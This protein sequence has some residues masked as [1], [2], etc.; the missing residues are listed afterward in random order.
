MGVSGAA[1]IVFSDLDYTVIFDSELDPQTEALIEAVR[2]R[3]R[4]VIVTARSLEECEP[5]PPIPSDA[6]VAENGAAVYLRQAGRDVLDLEWDRRMAPY[7]AALDAMRQELAAHGW[8]IHH[9]LRAFS[10]GVERSGKSARDVEWARGRLP[11]GLQLQLSRNTA[12]AYLEVF[13]EVAGKD[14][15]VYRVCQDH[16]V[17]PE[18]SFGLGDNTNDLDMLRVVGYPLAPGNCHPEVR[19]LV[20][21]RGG[22]VAKEHGHAGAQEILRNVLQRLA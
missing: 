10:A 12:G 4:F 3:A 14:Q 11:A 16:G 18:Q 8:R 2:L 20:L 5:L 19:E 22:Y 21:A 9:K 7:Q 17:E 15:A 1:P 6:L 13:P